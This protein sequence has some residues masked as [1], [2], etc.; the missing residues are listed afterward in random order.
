MKRKYAVKTRFS[1]T[2]T[3]FITAESKA[4][5]RK[6]VENHCG[7]VSDCNIHSSLPADTV[8][9]KFPVHPDKAVLGIRKEA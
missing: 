5:A 9:W 4:E 7:M 3:F 1:F 6:Y 8:D 2:G